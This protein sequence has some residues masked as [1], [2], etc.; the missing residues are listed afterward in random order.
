MGYD[1]ME[2]RDRKDGKQGKG[3]ERSGA[4]GEKRKEGNRA[5]DRVE[6]RAEKGKG[7]KGVGRGGNG[8]VVRGWEGG[9]KRQR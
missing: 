8:E 7:S 1:G 9:M 6:D 3:T 5:V 4:E 2:Q